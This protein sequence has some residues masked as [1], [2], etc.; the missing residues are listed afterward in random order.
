MEILAAM[1]GAL[2]V[3]WAVLAVIGVGTW[4]PW[5]LAVVIPLIW[6]AIRQARR[7]RE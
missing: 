4:F 1:A 6:A 3:V 7:R 5:W 2:I